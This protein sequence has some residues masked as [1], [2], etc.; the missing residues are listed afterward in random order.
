M[1]CRVCSQETLGPARLCQT[2]EAAMKR[3]REVMTA[4]SKP[5][6]P[7]KASAPA[8]RPW[9][10]GLA[11]IGVSAGAV[12]AV[13]AALYLGQR[14]K[15]DP[16]PAATRGSALTPLPL[17]TPAAL[18]IAPPPAHDSEWRPETESPKNAGTAAVASPHVART[19]AAA[20]P[21][22]GKA[23]RNVALQRSSGAA[24]PSGSADAARM[25]AASSGPAT[26]ADGGSSVGVADS[27]TRGEAAPTD[28]WQALT[29]AL[30]RCAS[31]G[32]LTRVM[33]EERARWKYC[34]GA[35]GEVAQCPV[36][37]RADSAR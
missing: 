28:R 31:E 5:A 26:D 33:C 4:G 13:T 7:P 24:S 1:K 29:N 36:G 11:A 22:A 2:C 34:E 32:F 3:A 37:R 25:A 16:P 21:S 23:P 9:R 19:A 15:T 20:N 6:A 27:G 17:Q 8:A 12:I 30:G 10:R 14:V 18:P 35:W